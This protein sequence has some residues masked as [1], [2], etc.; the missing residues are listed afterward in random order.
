MAVRRG[1]CGEKSGEK[2]EEKRTGLKTRHYKRRK[3]QEAG[4]TFGVAEGKSPGPVVQWCSEMESRR[5]TM[6]IG[7]RG[8]RLGDAA[9]FKI[10]K[11]H[12]P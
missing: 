7:L 8:L 11:P 4:L 9:K 3:K 10:K 6:W 1:K 2:S 5:R 12:Q